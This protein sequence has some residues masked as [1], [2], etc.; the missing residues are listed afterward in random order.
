MKGRERKGGRRRGRGGGRGSR[1]GD[2]GAKEEGFKGERAPLVEEL[3]QAAALVVYGQRHCRPLQHVPGL[4]PPTPHP[5]THTFHPPPPIQSRMR[6]L[7]RSRTH[8]RTLSQRAHARTHAHYYTHKRTHTYT[9]AHT[10]SWTPTRV[11]RQVHAPPASYLS[12]SSRTGF[13]SSPVA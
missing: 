11:C 6:P 4:P 12:L 2:G 1:E 10:R 8:A 5:P 9:R 3:A 7:T 13:S